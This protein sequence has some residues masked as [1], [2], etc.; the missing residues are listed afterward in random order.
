MTSV[1]GTEVS[2]ATD[3]CCSL[4]RCF[5]QASRGLCSTWLAEG[6]MQTLEA[7]R[8]AL[9]LLTP[10][11]CSRKALFFCPS[12]WS[13]EASSRKRVSE[14]EKG[15]SEELA[16]RDVWLLPETRLGRIQIHS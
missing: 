5:G 3:S 4:L 7:S 1:R 6:T 2:G 10:P 8:L 16:G 11:H 12:N 9:C 13:R 14:L 15:H